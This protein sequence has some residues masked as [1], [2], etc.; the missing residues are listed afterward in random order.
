MIS[1]IVCSRHHKIDQK[2]E[3][4]IQM[5]IGDVI[6]ELIWIDNADNKYS[7]CEAYNEGVLLAKY[8]YLCFI[9]EDIVFYS[10]NWGTMVMDAMTDTNVGLLGVQGCTY[11]DEST[12]YWTTSGFKKANTILPGKTE[13]KKEDDFPIPGNDVVIV[14]GMWMFTRKDLFQVIHW[15]ED[16][17]QGFHMYDLDLCMQIISM[18]M[19]IRL[20]DD[21]WIQHNSYG[22]WN[23]DFY[24][25]S[26]LFHKKWD[27]CFPV[28]VM[29]ITADVRRVARKASFHTIYK[30]G[31]E[32][33]KSKKRLTLLPYRIATKISLVL[34]KDIW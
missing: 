26:M 20:V 14:D 18:G 22:N 32:V 21:L 24:Q 34:G 9:H 19:T 31:M 3:N 15:D 27:R 28:S 10:N 11:F 2:L 8:P 16:T 17:F 30:Y 6:Y 1:I 12:L 23:E 5:T 29:P 13:K 25:G 4:N 7:I 33:A